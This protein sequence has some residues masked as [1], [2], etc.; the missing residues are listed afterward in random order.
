VVVLAEEGGLSFGGEGLETKTV[1]GMEA[2]RAR[3]DEAHASQ[4]ERMLLLRADRRVEYGR[5]RELFG[6]AQDIGFPGIMLRVNGEPEG[7][8]TVASTDDP[9]AAARGER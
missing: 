8:G 3:L 9:E 1:K 7:S 2:L 6:T 5:M 4:P